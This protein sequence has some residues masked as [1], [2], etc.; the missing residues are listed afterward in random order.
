MEHVLQIT[1]VLFS[2]ETVKK[3]FTPTHLWLS[4]LHCVALSRCGITNEYNEPENSKLHFIILIYI[5]ILTTERRNV[6]H[7]IVQAS[8]MSQYAAF[9]FVLNQTFRAKDSLIR[10]KK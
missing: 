7:L 6:K 8:H 3:T 5:L 10:L 4:G 1:I 2:S 9:F